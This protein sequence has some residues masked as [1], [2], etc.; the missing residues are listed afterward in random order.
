M[1]AASNMSSTEKS[2]LVLIR[3]MNQYFDRLSTVFLP[4]GFVLSAGIK[5]ESPGHIGTYD[6]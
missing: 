4:W 2:I 6:P 5:S 1:S 3:F